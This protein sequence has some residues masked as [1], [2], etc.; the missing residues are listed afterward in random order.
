MESYAV[1]WDAR[2]TGSRRVM[3]V[4]RKRLSFMGIYGEYMESDLYSLSNTTIPFRS[5]DLMLQNK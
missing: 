2:V 3:A 5:F 1:L 4:N